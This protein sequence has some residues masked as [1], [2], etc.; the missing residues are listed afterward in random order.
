MFSEVNAA[1]LTHDKTLDRTD[2]TVEEDETLF[3]AERRDKNEMKRRQKEIDKQ[4][5]DND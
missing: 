4:N 3:Y 2:L 5:N 1:D